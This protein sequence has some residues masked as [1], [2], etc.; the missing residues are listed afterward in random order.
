MHS[1][2]VLVDSTMVG[3]AGILII[4]LAVLLV[5]T[6]LLLFAVLNISATCGLYRD[7]KDISEIIARITNSEIK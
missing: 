3:L 6:P 2:I 4:R 1:S 7:N 5:R